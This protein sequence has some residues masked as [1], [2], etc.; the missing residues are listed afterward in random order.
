MDFF[1]VLCVISNENIGTKQ[2]MVNTIS[3][4]ITNDMNSFSNKN[5]IISYENETYQIT[6][7]DLNPNE[8]YNETTIY[9][10]RCENILRTNYEIYADETI[11]IY[12]MDYYFDEFLIPITEYKLF[13]PSKNQELSLSYCQGESIIIKIPVTI[14]DELYK[15]NPYS[16]YYSNSCFPNTSSTQCEDIDILNERINE[17]N[18]NKM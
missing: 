16:E 15:Y 3:N 13:A 4:E 2:N 9:L 14:N 17:F 7:T 10:D 8:N 6:T 12:K 18:N 5:L 1:N 11:I